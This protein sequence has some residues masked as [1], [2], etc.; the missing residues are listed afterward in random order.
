MPQSTIRSESTICSESLP[1]T[2]PRVPCQPAK[3]VLTQMVRS[4]REA[5][6]AWKSG[7]P[8]LFCTIPSVPP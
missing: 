8:A 1:V 7:C 5:P 3:A 4:S 2:V 6:S